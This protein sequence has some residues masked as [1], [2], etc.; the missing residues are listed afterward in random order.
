ME[1][2]NLYVHVFTFFLLYTAQFSKSQNLE[3]QALLTLKSQLNDPFDYLSNWNENG[4]H[5]KFFG[6]TCYSLSV[7]RI[8]LVN[9]SLSGTLSPSISSLQN[10]ESIELQTNSITGTI[11]LA[12]ANC[13][14]LQHLNLSSNGFIGKI[15]DFSPLRKLRALD[16]SVN[17]LN[18]EVTDLSS[19]Q[20]LQVLDLSGN[21]FSGKFPSWIGKATSLVQLSLA[22]ISFDEGEIPS[23]IGN[24]KNLTYLYLQKC[25]FIG[26][27]PSFIFELTALGTLDLSCNKLSGNFPKEISRLQ[28]LWKIELFENN[29]TGELPVELSKLTSLNEFDIS[30]NHMFGKLPTEIGKINFTVFQTYTN[31]FS[32]E[33]PKGFGDMKHLKSISIYQNKFSGEFPASL[34]RFSPLSDIDISENNFSG[35]FPRFLCQNNKL[36]YLL[37]LDNSFSGSF[38]DTY[39]TCKSLIRFRISQNHFTGNFPSGLWGLPYATIIDVANN[40]FNGEITSDIGISTTITQLAVQNNNFSREIPSE[41][42]KLSQLNKFNAFNNSFSGNIPSQIGELNQLSTLMLGKNLLSGHIPSEI[43][44]CRGLVELNLGQN[45]LTGEI[46]KSLSLLSSLN[47]LDLSSNMLD[48]SIPEGLQLLKLSHINFS[49]NKL[50]GQI[51]AQLLVIGGNEAFTNNVG[52]CVSN[53][54]PN[55]WH[56]G[57]YGD[58]RTF[59]VLVVMLVMLVILVAIAFV[60]YRNLK[61]EES[62]NKVDIEGGF[63]GNSDWKL[64]TFYPNEL[65]EEDIHKLDEKNLI[66]FGSTGKVYKLELTKKRGTFAVKQLWR[67]KGAK[68]FTTETNILRKIKHK[69]ILKLYSCLTRGDLSYLVFEYMPNGNLHEALHREAK[70]W[71]S[72]LNWTRRYNIALGAA[73]GI[74]YLHHDCSPAIIHC[75]IKSTNILLDDEYEAKIADFG[76]SKMSADS[77]YSCFAGTHGYMAPE[78]AYTL[79][80]TEKSDVYSYGVVLLELLTGRIPIESQ[81]GEGK[82]IVYWVSVHVD[83]QNFEEIFDS[84]LSSSSLDDMIKVLKVAMLCTTKLP[85][86]RPTMREVVAML[87]HAYPCAAVNKSKICPKT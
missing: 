15:P 52:L 87:V 24:L 39:S 5:C 78:L 12:L 55:H 79:K 27:I 11:P 61:H 65:E 49:N 32:G 44:N 76:I 22:H 48:G 74:M 7:T 35:E 4:S 50:S 45:S 26:E 38:P 41:I 59:M 80:V 16:L 18:G 31:N 34:G 21:K 30:K 47:S 51:P 60:T 10:L 20:N 1:N 6:I 64:E 43:G 86:V 73:K 82:D 2:F 25:G 46:P 8:S 75:D 9:M 72:E 77:Y 14:K 83:A 33:F 56:D 19:L 53:C 63:D 40:N 57:K 84:R 28:N 54:K 62:C 17:N 3:T 68:V 69:N 66:G 37:A 42:G 58:R 29:L 36:Q 67:G 85:T 23:S 71:I 70:G 13:T 81:F